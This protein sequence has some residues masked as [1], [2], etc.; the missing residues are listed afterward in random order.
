MEA[1]HTE[2]RKARKLDKLDKLDD[3]I[4]VS[5]RNKEAILQVGPAYDKTLDTWSKLKA[6]NSIGRR[7]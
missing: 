1:E 7:T 2:C 4:E 3:L 6:R 5:A